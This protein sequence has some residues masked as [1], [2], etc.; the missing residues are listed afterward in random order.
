MFVCF[1]SFL[2]PIPITFWLSLS[3]SPSLDVCASSHHPAR[4]RLPMFNSIPLVR[5]A[6]WT[7]LVAVRPD[8]C[9]ARTDRGHC[10][11]KGHSLHDPCPSASPTLYAEPADRAVVSLA[12]TVLAHTHNHTHTQRLSA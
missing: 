4:A 12:C 1:D 10:A 7:I 2:I 6:M 5:L 11:H 8:H 3:L 9:G